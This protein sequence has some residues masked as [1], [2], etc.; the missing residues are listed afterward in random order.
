MA[1]T[2][3]SLFSHCV[4]DSRLPWSQR[5]QIKYVLQHWLRYFKFSA[6]VDERETKTVSTAATVIP[7]RQKSYSFWLCDELAPRWLLSRLRMTSSLTSFADWL[8]PAS[9]RSPPQRTGL[10][11][12]HHPQCSPQDSSRAL[13]RAHRSPPLPE[14]HSPA[15]QRQLSQGQHSSMPGP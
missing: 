2:L 8:P 15:I 3:S 4:Q 9:N 14:A 12:T 11:L 1:Q 7:E 6:R 5:Q 13:S 10:T